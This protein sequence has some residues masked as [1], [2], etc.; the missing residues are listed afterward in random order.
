MSSTTGLGPFRPGTGAIPPYLA[1]RESEQALLQAFLTDLA[2]GVAPGTQV[3]LHGPRG[4]GKTVLLDWL[5]RE[6]ASRTGIETAVLLPSEFSD[7]PGLRKRLAPQR[8]WQR[9]TTAEVAAAG[10]SWKPG[11]ETLPP[12]AE[13]LTARARVGA[14]LLL[15]DEAHTL[16]RESGRALLTAA[17]EVGRKSPF[18]LVLAGT[19]NL[20]AHLDSMGVSFW[21]RAR[22]LRVGRLGKEATAEALRRPFEREDIG[23]S[24]DVLDAMVEA[25]QR[26]P[27]FVQ[28]LGSAV[29]R[30][31]VSPSEPGRTVSAAVLDAALPEFEAARGEYY[32]HR[33]RELARSGL[34]SVGRAVAQA[35][36]RRATLNHAALEEA[37][38][39][40]LG[41]KPAAERVRSATDALSHLGF[42]WTVAARPEWGA[43]HPEP[44]GVRAPPRAVTLN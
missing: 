44:H 36:H 28:L 21:N 9:L 12:A 43:R 5:E 37:V 41:G 15:V 8:W 34:L 30:R 26:Y 33:F 23:V 29:W 1:G 42:I 10:F 18:L 17:Q 16:E 32:A 11:E 19:P 25:S 13:I 4:N 6:A 20:E 24:G 35:F 38:R 27:Y 31:A 39:S 7:E 2:D 3:V 14:L 22:Q 40:G